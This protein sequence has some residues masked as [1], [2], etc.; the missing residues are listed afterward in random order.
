[1]RPVGLV[2]AEVAAAG[3]ERARRGKVRVVGL[4]G[5]MGSAG[6]LGVRLRWGGRGQA[7]VGRS[8]GAVVRSA[9]KTVSREAT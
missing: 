5:V 2:G 4:V 6:W 8:A 3:K 1:M 7:A 9:G